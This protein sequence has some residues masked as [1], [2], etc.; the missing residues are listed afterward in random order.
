[1]NAE[2]TPLATV[3]QS[4]SSR[5]AFPVELPNGPWHALPMKPRTWRRLPGSTATWRWRVIG[6]GVSSEWLGHGSVMV[7]WKCASMM[8]DMFDD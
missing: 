5:S 8:F 1:M 3:S 4:K 7:R 2:N 6:E